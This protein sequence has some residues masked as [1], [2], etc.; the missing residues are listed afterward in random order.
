MTITQASANLLAHFSPEERDVPDHADYPGRNAIVLE[1][2]NGALQECYAM[3]SPWTRWD[4]RGAIL[5]TA[6]TVSIAVTNGST[7]GTITGWADWMAGCTIVIGGHDCDN[8]IRNASS[9][10]VLKYPYDGTTGTVSAVVYQDCVSAASDVLAVYG[11]VRVGGREILPR[12][13]TGLSSIQTEDYGGHIDFGIIRNTYNPRVAAAAGHPLAYVV[14]TWSSGQYAAPAV[15]VRLVPANN[16]AGVMDYNVTLK[17]PAITNIAATDLIPVPFGFAETIFMPVA[18]QKLTSSPF[19]LD[20]S[21]GEEIRRAYET[22]ITLLS[23]LNPSKDTGI[24]LI[25]RF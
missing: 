9:P 22:A 18:R 13:N 8:Q 23:S 5:K 2:M 15:R 17:P 14:E 6:T 20:Q 7:A 12:P 3:G 1:A 24:S 25:P 4:A 19:F 21:G 10:V 11:P 16:L